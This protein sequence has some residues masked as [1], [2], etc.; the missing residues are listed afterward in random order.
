MTLEI[1]VSPKKS[2]IM[3][4]FPDFYIF[5]ILYFSYTDITKSKL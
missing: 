2:E 5:F 4:K 1:Y 3:H